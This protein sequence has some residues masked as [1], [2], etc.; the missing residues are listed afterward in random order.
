ME[1]IKFF[2]IYKLLET[3]FKES[4]DVMKSAKEFIF[5]LLTKE[6]LAEYKERDGGVFSGILDYWNE[7]GKVNLL[8]LDISGLR[9]RDK[10][11]KSF[12]DS[13]QSSLFISF[14]S[15]LRIVLM[16]YLI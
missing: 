14:E 7:E 12:A 2:N 9:I 10:T 15:N 5:T 1:F 11:L 13:K 4:D 6:N 8:V 16:L 3:S